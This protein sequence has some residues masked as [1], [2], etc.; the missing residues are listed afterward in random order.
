MI[1]TDS[2][3]TSK[4][5]TG[6]DSV[7]ITLPDT[8]DASEMRYPASSASGAPKPSADLNIKLVDYGVDGAVGGGDD[9]EHELTHNAANDNK[10]SGGQWT[11]L[12]IKSG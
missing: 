5:V 2:G 1:V 10:V 8:L 12:E 9:S 6:A 7:T 11:D 3:D 4:K